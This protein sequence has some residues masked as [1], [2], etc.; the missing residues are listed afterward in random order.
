[1]SKFQIKLF[2]KVLL[3]QHFLHLSTPLSSQVTVVGQR[4][5]WF[6]FVSILPELKRINSCCNLLEDILF[7]DSLKYAKIYIKPEVHELRNWSFLS[8]SSNIF[9]RQVIFLIYS[10]FQKHFVFSWLYHGG[11]KEMWMSILFPSEEWVFQ[12]FL[13]DKIGRR[14]IQSD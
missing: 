2:L 14:G 7:V 9:P 5:I 6:I 10:K 3:N 13:G 8:F 12:L 4:I 11:V 1:M